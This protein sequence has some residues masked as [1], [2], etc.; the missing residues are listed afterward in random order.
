MRATEERLGKDE[1]SP[2]GGMTLTL[3]TR[4]KAIICTLR[5]CCYNQAQQTIFLLCCHLM[6]GR[7]VALPVSKTASFKTMLQRH[8]V[9]KKSNKSQKLYMYEHGDRF[10][11]MSAIY[12]QTYCLYWKKCHEKKQN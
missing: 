12:Q 7:K 2:T 4:I 9:K 8:F 3:V 10:G 11:E 5:S 6:N 1:L